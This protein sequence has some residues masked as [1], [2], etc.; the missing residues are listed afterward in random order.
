MVPFPETVPYFCVSVQ[1][2]TPAGDRGLVVGNVDEAVEAV[3]ADAQVV[4]PTGIRR[5][6]PARGQ[7]LGSQTACLAEERLGANGIL[8]NGVTCPVE[9]G[10]GDSVVIVDVVVELPNAIIDG[11]D[12]RKAVGKGAARSGVCP[13]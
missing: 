3:P 7:K 5:P 11:D 2:F 9:I 8:A 4:Y 10:T 12:I 6:G 1:G 13:V